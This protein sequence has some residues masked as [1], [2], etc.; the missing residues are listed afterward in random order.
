MKC[1]RD[2]FKKKKIKTMNIKRATN[3]QLSKTESKKQKT[4]LRKQPELELNHRYGD[5]LDGYQL[6]EGR[7][8]M[9]EKCRD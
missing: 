4:K 9:E 3:S 5:H 8:R 2:L 1:L 6:G 7:G